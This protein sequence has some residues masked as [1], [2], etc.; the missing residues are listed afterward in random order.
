LKIFYGSHQN[1]NKEERLSFSDRIKNFFPG[2]INKVSQNSAINKIIIVGRH[3]QPFAKQVIDILNNLLPDSATSYHFDSNYQ[4]L[5]TEGELVNIYSPP[6]G[7]IKNNLKESKTTMIE[8][9]RK[10]GFTY[11]RIGDPRLTFI[12][13]D[14]KLN[15]V[16]KSEEICGKCYCDFTNKVRYLIK[17]TEN[18]RS[19]LF[20]L[21]GAWKYYGYKF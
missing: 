2:V 14:C 8:V 18:L 3:G 15:Y 4:P 9:V 12:K 21:L 1:I 5:L 6:C 10:S 7:T 16:Q 19:D 20:V 17:L 11:C 13:I